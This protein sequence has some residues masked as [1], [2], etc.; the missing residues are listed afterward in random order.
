MSDGRETRPGGGPGRAEHT[1]ES[2]RGQKLYTAGAAAIP[3]VTSSTPPPP[4][5]PPSG[6]G[7]KAAS[8]S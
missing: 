3:V 5:A 7:A 2:E 6:A 1:F 4:P 8:D